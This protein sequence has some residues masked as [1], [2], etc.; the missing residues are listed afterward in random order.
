MF[1]MTLPRTRGGRSSRKRSRIES[2]RGTTSARTTDQGNSPSPPPPPV[3]F[4]RKSNT[5]NFLYGRYIVDE[6]VINTNIVKMITDQ[7]WSKI[8]HLKCDV[9]E[10]MMKQ[11]MMVYL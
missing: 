7:G 9:H 4:P 2:S 11:F 6:E 1:I 5:R 10:S 3:I 8:S